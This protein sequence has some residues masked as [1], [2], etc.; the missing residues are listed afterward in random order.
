L[1]GHAIAMTRRKGEI[2]SRRINC[3][4]PHQVALRAEQVKGEN[5]RITHDFCGDLSLAPRG[6]T[7]RW[8]SGNHIVFCFADPA[9]ADR[10]RER[11]G[12][13]HFDPRDRG[14]GNNWYQWRRR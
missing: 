1:N 11:F 7:V 2:T 14:R 9:H 13:E 12:G 4:W 10:F 5:Y 6:H 3:D 8:G